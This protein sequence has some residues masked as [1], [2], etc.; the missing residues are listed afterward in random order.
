MFDSKD[1]MMNEL[2]KQLQNEDSVL[3]VQLNDQRLEKLAEYDV[4]KGYTNIKTTPEELRN[5]FSEYK[6]LVKK[7]ES[8][9]K[10]LED[11]VYS[12]WGVLECKREEAVPEDNV[13]VGFS[14][15]DVKVKKIAKVK[16]GKKRYE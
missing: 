11:D 6:T 2:L 4:T 16:K 10:C 9:L 13:V 1:D 5:R 7:G 3:R 15:A 8:T 12:R 14:M